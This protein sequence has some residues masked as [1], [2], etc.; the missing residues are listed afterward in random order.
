MGALAGMQTETRT[1]V[2]FLELVFPDRLKV[3]MTKAFCE[4]SFGNIAENAAWL[5]DVVVKKHPDSLFAQSYLNFAE[6]LSGKT[7]SVDAL[8]RVSQTGSDVEREFAEHAIGVLKKSG[9]SII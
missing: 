2:R 8:R 3:M 5:R 1:I 6:V 4:M 9:Y 7:N